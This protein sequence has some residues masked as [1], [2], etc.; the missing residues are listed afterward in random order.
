MN[1][2][3]RIKHIFAHHYWVNDNLRVPVSRHYFHSTFGVRRRHEFNTAEGLEYICTGTPG[4]GFFVHS[5]DSIGYRDFVRKHLKT[6][7][8][9][10]W[11]FIRGREPN[12]KKELERATP[13][14]QTETD[15]TR[16]KMLDSYVNCLTIGREA[17]L[18]QRLERGVKDT[19]H[20]RFT[21]ECI[22]VLSQLKGQFSSLQ[23]DLYAAALKPMTYLSEAQQQYWERTV[24]AF[25]AFMCSR[26]IFSIEHNIETG[27]TEYVEVYANMGIFDFI[28]MPGGTPTIYD[29]KGYTYYFYPQGCIKANSSLDFRLIPAAAMKIE[30]S[31]VDVNTLIGTSHISVAS[32]QHN[33]RKKAKSNK[34]STLLAYSRNGMMGYL[35]IPEMG[36]SLLC[37]N[38]E[39]TQRFVDALTGRD[40]T[41]DDVGFLPPPASIGKGGNKQLG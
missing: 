10:L 1:P 2:L 25:H 18:L 28:Y 6:S 14:L 5:S 33:T 29:G 21:K 27:T 22:S 4:T 15:V 13:A 38:V 16:R 19:M 34:A 32:L 24:S 41:W 39:N 8:S 11:N 36:L 35:S 3:R 40:S 9:S 12:Y 26:R 30:Y 37:S 31:P 20:S 23:H 17:E 7:R